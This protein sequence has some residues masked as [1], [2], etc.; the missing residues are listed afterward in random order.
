[1][2]SSE[3]AQCSLAWKPPGGITHAAERS[4]I[5]DKVSVVELGV[6]RDAA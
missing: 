4:G 2:R 6:G 5:V 1:M 3:H